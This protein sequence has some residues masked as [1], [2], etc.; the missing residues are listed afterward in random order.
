ME[1]LWIFP[2]HEE[3]LNANEKFFIVN[4]CKNYY[5]PDGYQLHRARED[6][7]ICIVTHG[8]L[9]LPLSNEVIPK[10]GCYIFSPRTYQRVLYKTNSL[11]YWF[12]VQGNEVNALMHELKL[13]RNKVFSIPNNH[14][15]AILDEIILEYMTKDSHYE[16][17]SILLAKK[18]LYNLPREI[19]ANN[20]NNTLNLL[21]NAV[22]QLYLNPKLSNEEC[23]KLC[24]TTT[25]NFIRSFKA[26]Y[27]MTPHKFK[28]Q[29]II[30]QAK[31]LLSQTNYSITD[32][33]LMLGFD[34]NPLYFSTFFKALT[35][36]SP[37]D[38]RAENKNYEQ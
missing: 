27:Q 1:Y 32:I 21:K 37:S 4:C 30:S 10:N 12:H 24:F 16:E 2:M 35:G 9:Y 33:A 18:F 34:N 28:Q 17:T 13:P 14:A 8:E 19:S 3:N 6:W 22:S 38:Y 11:T 15:T 5:S 7:S 23:A 29:L 31:E 26:H 20:N 25:E 36:T